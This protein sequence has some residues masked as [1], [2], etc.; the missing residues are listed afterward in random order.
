LIAT[1]NTSVATS[2]HAIATSDA[3]IATSSRVKLRQPR[4]RNIDA[5]K[6]IS[7]ILQ[8]FLWLNIDQAI[9]LTSFVYKNK[10]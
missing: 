3:S 1:S 7:S 6:R 9:T 5:C 8:F 2:N 4:D 10:H